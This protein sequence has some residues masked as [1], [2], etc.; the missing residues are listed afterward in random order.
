MTDVTLLLVVVGIALALRITG[1]S[2]NPLDNDE[3]A[4]LGLCSLETWAL[5]TD[6]RLHP[7]LAQLTMGWLAG[8]RMNVDVGRSVSVVAGI[9][10]CAL[11]FAVARHRAGRAAGFLAGV[12]VATAPA[13]LAISQLARGYALL[14]LW[15]LLAH[16]CLTRAL[17]SGK[18][19]W[20]T[21]YSIAVALGLATEYLSLAPLVLDALFAFVFVRKRRLA[22][23]ALFGSFLA[24]FAASGWLLGHAWPT[25]RLGVGGPPQPK[26]GAWSALVEIAFAYS[27]V[28]APW[29][30]IV[31]AAVVISACERKQ[32]ANTDARLIASIVGIVLVVVV[33]GALTAVRPRYALHGLPLAGIL[34][35]TVA[36]VARRPGAL[37]IALIS[38]ASHL[39]LLPC[40]LGGTCE[41]SEIR[42]AP[43]IPTLLARVTV[44]PERPIVI[45]PTPALGE[46][47]WRL[48]RTLPGPDA[49]RPC[50]AAL[51]A[52]AR[53]RRF[54]GV[55]DLDDVNALRPL[56]PS[57]FLLAREPVAETGCHELARE[58][59]SVLFS[60]DR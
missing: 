13:L 19:R 26:S 10:T 38:L 44:D 60:C 43:E 17:D 3:P 15:V 54:Y 47:S 53:G 8:C 14:A 34:V 7:P 33:G 11:A 49:P 58:A 29:I 27:G 40:Y 46:I 56:E 20:W 16:A 28:I 48:A 41:R 57:F 30:A 6:S 39:A 52:E 31:C 59:D 36:F 35:S 18:S 50:P 24:G 37:S 22:R 25:L 45:L 21:L 12:F 2:T 42:K 55:G 1:L 51:C 32:L 5:E 23:T 4:S 9:F